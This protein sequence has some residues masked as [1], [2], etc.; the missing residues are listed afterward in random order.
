MHVTDHA[1]RLSQVEQGKFDIIYKSGPSEISMIDVRLLG[2]LSIGG[3]RPVVS[4][5]VIKNSDRRSVC[6]T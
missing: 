3:E 2:S 1:K 5:L 4:L 6:R